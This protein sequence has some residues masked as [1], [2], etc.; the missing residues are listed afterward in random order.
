[1]PRITVQG[2]MHGNSV[3]HV[4]IAKTFQQCRSQTCPKRM[5]ADSWLSYIAVYFMVIR[6]DRHHELSLF[7]VIPKSAVRGRK[8]AQVL[9]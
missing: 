3:E 8:D 7:T 9:W 4:C 2:I 5:F 1:M 6:V